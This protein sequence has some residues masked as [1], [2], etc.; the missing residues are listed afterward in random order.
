MTEPTDL[1]GTYAYSRQAV[2]DYL[3]AVE[4]QR[5]EL[6]ASIADA[7]ARTARATEL[8]DRIVALEQRVGELIVGAHVDV[9]TGR[10]GQNV[11]TDT[12]AVEAL[13][14]KTILRPPGSFGEEPDSH[15]SE[16]WAPSSPAPSQGWET[17][18]G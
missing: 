12:S 4:A 9:G 14:A 11:F 15:T 17:D 18:R 7:R 8:T 16:T 10:A 6:R 13:K 5:A 2:E 1:E 3:R